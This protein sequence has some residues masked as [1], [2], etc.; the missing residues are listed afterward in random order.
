MK[1]NKIGKFMVQSSLGSQAHEWKANPIES[2][3]GPKRN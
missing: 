2:T 3:L 1:N